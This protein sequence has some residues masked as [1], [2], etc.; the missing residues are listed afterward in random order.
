MTLDVDTELYDDL[1]EL[2]ETLDRA[3]AEALGW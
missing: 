3:R 1:D 2:T